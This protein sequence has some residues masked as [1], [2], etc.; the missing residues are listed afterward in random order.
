MSFLKW[1]LFGSGLRRCWLCKLQ[2]VIFLHLFSHQ[3]Q[4]LYL[5]HV[6]LG[7]LRAFRPFKKKTEVKK[8]LS[9]SKWALQGL[10]SKIEEQRQCWVLMAS[11]RTPRTHDAAHGISSNRLRS[12]HSRSRIWPRTSQSRSVMQAVS[13]HCSPQQSYKFWSK[14]VTDYWKTLIYLLQRFSG[15][16]HSSS[17]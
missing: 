11:S 9:S 3:V 17:L 14:T 8:A 15:S 12:Q 6:C 7:F 4:V 10:V 1:S 2:M 16:A 13:A 5:G